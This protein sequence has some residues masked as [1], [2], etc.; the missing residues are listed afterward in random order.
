LEPGA[1]INVTVEAEGFATQVIPVTLADTFFTFLDVE[2]L[3]QIP[4]VVV[5]SAPDSGAAAFRHVD[6]ISIEFSRPM[7]QASV[8]AAFSIDPETDGIFTWTSGGTRMI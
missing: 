8:E 2:L 4:P 3:S 6:P 7:D 1:T 5:S